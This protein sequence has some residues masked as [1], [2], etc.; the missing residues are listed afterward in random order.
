VDFGIV[1]GNEPPCEGLENGEM[2]ACM[3][4]HQECSLLADRSSEAVD[5]V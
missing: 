3:M 4:Q 2:Y 5:A 1:D